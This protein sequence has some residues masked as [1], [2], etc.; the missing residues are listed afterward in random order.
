MANSMTWNEHGNAYN[1]EKLDEESPK[2]LQLYRYNNGCVL[3]TGIDDTSKGQRNNDYF[4]CNI[5]LMLMNYRKCVQEHNTAVF[6][7]TDTGGDVF[8][9]TYGDAAGNALEKS[10][11][12]DKVLYM[13]NTLRHEDTSHLFETG[14][15]ENMKVEMLEFKCACVYDVKQQ[16]SAGILTASGSL[17]SSTQN[18]VSQNFDVCIVVLQKADRDAKDTLIEVV[19]PNFNYYRELDHGYLAGAG[20][21]EAESVAKA[22]VL[23]TCAEDPKS[24]GNDLPTAMSIAGKDYVLAVI[25]DERSMPPNTSFL[26]SSRIYPSNHANTG[27]N[28]GIQWDV[29]APNTGLSEENCTHRAAWPNAGDKKSITDGVEITNNQPEIPRSMLTG[30]KAVQNK[31]MAIFAFELPS[32]AWLGYSFNLYYVKTKRCSTINH[33]NCRTCGVPAA[34]ATRRLESRSLQAGGGSRQLEVFLKMD[35]PKYILNPAGTMFDG[36]SRAAD[37]YLYDSAAVVALMGMIATL[38]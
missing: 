28:A 20:S 27:D 18:E 33:K 24:Y 19:R 36:G 7:S 32:T 14:G 15:N 38:F 21:S 13:A 35:N 34:N 2:C 12:A 22:L 37:N 4:D 1:K 30:D 3:L 29:V 9:I 10:V 17:G 16:V 5:A 25:Q 23:R 11:G 31:S 6:G 26:T 8:S